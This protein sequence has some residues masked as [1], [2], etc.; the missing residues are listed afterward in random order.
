MQMWFVQRSSQHLYLVSLPAEL[1]TCGASHV[2]FRL[3]LTISMPQDLGKSAV[4]L[5]NILL[6]TLWSVCSGV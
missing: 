2:A 6:T 1:G 5:H 4:T 3:S